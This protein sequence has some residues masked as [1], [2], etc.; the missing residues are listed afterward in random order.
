MATTKPLDTEILQ[1][2]A[3][4][5]ESL[6]REILH[7]AKYLIVNHAQEITQNTPPAKK[8]RVGILKGTF[9]L[10]LPDDFDEPLEDFKEYM[11]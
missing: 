4:M 9:V 11:E 5:P 2:I 6:T 3:Q 1:T 8:R 7:Y 10:P